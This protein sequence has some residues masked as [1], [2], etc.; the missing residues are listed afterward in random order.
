M[1][2]IKIIAF[3]LLIVAGTASAQNRNNTKCPFQFLYHFGDAISDTGNSVRVL[4]LLPPTRSP[5]GVT[6]PGSPTGRWSNGRVDV[7]YVADAVGLPNIVPYLSMYDSRSYDGVI[8]SVAGST[9]LNTSFFES[10]GI[11]TPPYD[12]PLDTQLNWFRSYLQ[13]NCANQTECAKRQPSNSAVLF[14]FSELNDIGYALVQGKSIQEVTNYVPLLVEA[15]INA[16]REVIKLGATRVV[17]TTAAPLGCYPYILTA[18]TTND[19]SAYD[20]LGCLR[21]V[22]SIAV[23]FNANLTASFLALKVEF[24]SVNI[25][26][27]DYYA[28]LRVPINFKT[29]ILASAKNS[30]CPFHILYRFGDGISDNGNSVRVPPFGPILPP[31]R[32]PYGVTFPGYPTGRWSDGRLEID[33]VA[34]AVGLPNIV[35]YLSI[36]ASRSYDGVV[37]SVAGSTSLNAS[38]LESRGI[39]VPPFHIPLDTQL[40]WFRTF[41]QLNCTS[42]TEC[43]KRHPSKSSIIIE[44]A[45][46]NDIGYALVQGESIQEVTNYIPLIVEA[47]INAAREVIKLGATRVVY[48]TAAPLG[49]YPYILTALTTNDTSAYDGLGCLKAVNNVAVKFNKNLLLSLLALQAEFP[50][51]QILPTD[52]YE[53]VIAQ[54]KLKMPLAFNADN[55][56]RQ[57][58]R[59]SSGLTEFGDFNY[60]INCPSFRVGVEANNLRDWDTIPSYCKNYIKTYLTK[61]QWSLDVEALA[62]EAFEYAATFEQDAYLNYCWVFDVEETLL[63]NLN[64]LASSDILD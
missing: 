55:P 8:F 39:G 44:F 24:P 33:Y 58:R 41:L 13:S 60:K 42:Q 6:F 64:Y 63:S 21:A 26:P 59:P 34:K 53:T 61:N 57:L 36:D 23:K 46:L 37:F 14:E 19:T 29:P 54:I 52:Y 10:G 48:T 12:I 49:C 32:D 38:F 22:N 5:Y 62:N 40:T 43:A 9:A 11:S 47:Q 50:N 18:L 16:A 35:P 7:D 15:Q 27:A 4:P 20:G 31:T 1:K 30:K 45:E 51:V 2:S 3:L 28:T 17:Y 56:I 25:L